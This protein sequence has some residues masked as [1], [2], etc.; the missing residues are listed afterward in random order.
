MR[1]NL[2]REAKPATGPFARHIRG[3]AVC[4]DRG[5]LGRWPAPAAPSAKTPPCSRGWLLPHK[6]PGT[7]KGSRGAAAWGGRFRIAQTARTGALGLLWDCIIPLRARGVLQ[8]CLKCEG[9]N[10]IHLLNIT[11]SLT[12]RRATGLKRA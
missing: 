1:G 11:S 8:P 6:L 10:K 2:R 3:P 9:P 7:C 12:R 5:E 4:L